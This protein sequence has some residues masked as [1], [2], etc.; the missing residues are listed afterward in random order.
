[1]F[2]WR[3][4]LLEADAAEPP[5]RTGSSEAEVRL[6]ALYEIVASIN[7]LLDPLPLLERVMTTAVSI[8]G[9]ERGL[10]ILIDPK[11]GEL[12][13]TMA[14][15]LDPQTIVDATEYSKSIVRE[16]GQ[17]RSILAID[18]GHDSRFL[19]FRSVS[20]LKIKSLM[21]VPLRLRERVI[22]TVYLDSRLT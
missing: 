4:A 18:A 2:G 16:A 14:R 17:G 13:V 11:S 10:L 15:G 8:A 7:S 6:Q 20:L 5:A 19:S 3:R 1:D 12:E 22:G 21:C 9:A